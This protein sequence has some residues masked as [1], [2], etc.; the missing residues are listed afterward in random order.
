VELLDAVEVRVLGS[1]LEKEIATP[2][3]YPLTTNALVNA[4]NQKSNREPVVSYDEGAVEDAL[5]CLRA[6]RL[7]S[8]ITGA[9]LR[10]PKHRQV[11][12]ETFNLGRREHA[13]LCVLMLR[14]PQTAGEIRERASRLHEFS[15]TEAV[16]N[17]IERL[18]ERQPDALVA[19][20]P[21]LPGTKEPRYAH[22]L[23]GSPQFEQPQ[24]V[25]V[26]PARPREDRLAALELEV[27]SLREDFDRI[28]EQFASFRRQFE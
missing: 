27:Q 6:K 25:A 22:L 23:S 18:M 11:F 12:S 2:E 21:R 4:C 26:E 15:D 7:A 24:P 14:G 17:C 16:E 3:Y 9:G 8:T 5:E 13:V 28:R 20:L 1:L 19:K 10:V